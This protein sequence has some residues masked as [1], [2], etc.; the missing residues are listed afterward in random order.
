MVNVRKKF[1]I[2]LSI[3]VILGM[4]IPIF[5]VPAV[6]DASPS[7]PDF[8][9]EKMAPDLAAI[10]ARG[11]LRVAIPEEDLFAFF[12]EDEKGNLF[13]IDIDL[14]RNI[15]S[16]LG[17]EAEFV[18]VGGDYGNL[19]E[20]LKNGNV[21]VVIATYS[22]TLDRIQYVDF[23]EP[24]LSLRFAVMVNKSAMVTA[25]ID[26]NPIPYMKANT[27]DIAVNAGTSH[28]DAAKMLFPKANIILTDSYD[29]ASQMVAEG[30]A[31]ATFS[32][33]LLFYSQH[34][35]YS[36]YSVYCTTFA[37]E[38]VKDEFCVGVNRNCTQLLD[39]VNLYLATSLPI[40][41]DDVERIYE[42]RYESK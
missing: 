40:T 39:F 3:L 7:L 13:G 38:D 10:K 2:V 6:A 15:A 4:I 26:H 5:A 16:A 21:D 17:V 25:G 20:E 27:V 24:Y 32:G 42:E 14:A 31:F 30:K 41:V 1:G 19:S 22:H 33:E 37:L 35:D 29:E 34:L 8:L 11:S 18:R 28:V 9:N 23:S 36:G 12:E